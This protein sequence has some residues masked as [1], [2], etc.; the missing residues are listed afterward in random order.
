MKSEQLFYALTGIHDRFIEEAAGGI[1]KPNRQVYLRYGVLAASLL[2]VCGL[3]GLS[4][5]GCGATGGGNAMPPD[6]VSGTHDNVSAEDA[7]LL[8]DDAAW[9]GG[10]AAEGG[11]L[12]SEAPDSPA[13]AP[14]DVGTPANFVPPVGGTETAPSA[15]RPAAR[16]PQNA[17]GSGASGGGQPE[18]ALPQASAGQP[19]PYSYDEAPITPKESVQ[20][21]MENDDATLQTAKSY[22][23]GAGAAESA[24]APA[25]SSALPR[26]DI[27][28]Y[29]MIPLLSL[30]EGRLSAAREITI[31]LSAY[32]E[33]GALQYQDCYTLENTESFDRTVS[34]LYPD[35]EQVAITANGVPL[36]PADMEKY[37][38]PAG[39]STKI[40]F[41]GSKTLSVSPNSIS[42]IEVISMSDNSLD[43]ISQSAV[44]VPCPGLT[45]DNQNFGF[46][47][48]SG[49]LSVPLQTEEPCNFLEFSCP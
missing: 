23:A 44:L 6:V 1:P 19:V 22:S 14:Q 7:P 20:T 43:F 5:R 13:A 29:P 17:A 25:M 46:D 11:V 42:R 12:P 32:P 33:T 45:F 4:L 18:T 49:K 31:D 40:V 27:Q 16:N 15:P 48:S 9:E 35:A 36:R 37:T 24:G 34:L 8:H 21:E 26:A 3:G 39:S 30:A 10:T 28:Y 41:S 47:L 38:I 2:L